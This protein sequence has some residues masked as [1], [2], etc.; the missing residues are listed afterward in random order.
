MTNP[1]DYYKSQQ[2]K[3]FDRSTKAMADYKK[4]YDTKYE[5]AVSLNPSEIQ[6]KFARKAA[7]LSGPSRK[8]SEGIFNEA[9]ANKDYAYAA[10][11]ADD[12]GDDVDPT[13]STQFTNALT[14]RMTVNKM[15]GLID[16]FGAMVP[17]QDDYAILTQ[18]MIRLF[19]S[20]VI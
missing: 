2:P 17:P 11:I 12:T 6:K 10:Q 14:T 18:W 20:S 4:E 13:S 16:D 9:M 3:T 19:N 8:Y 5:T 1:E 7:T 15:A